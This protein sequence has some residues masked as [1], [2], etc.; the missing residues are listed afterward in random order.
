MSK[1]D[2][3]EILRLHA[4]DYSQNRIT[5]SVGSSHHTVKAVL[6]SAAE[7]NIMWPLD[8]DVSN[9]EL[10]LLLFPDKYKAMSLYK[11][12]DYAYIHRELAKPGVTL[13]LLWEEYCRECHESHRTPYMS[14]QFGDKY[15]KWARITKATM[16]IT[17]KPGDAMEVD[18]AGDTIPVFDPVT[19][20]SDAAYLF[21]TVLP[22]S[23][24]VYAEV[25][26]DMKQENWLLCHIHAYRY[27]GG[28]TRILIPD[29]CK[30]A[31]ISNTRYD[32]ILNKSYREMA[33][34][35]NT[36]I[37]PA[38]VRKPQDKSHAEGSVRF[39]ETWIIASLRNQK[40]FA[41]GEVKEAVFEK[42]KELNERPFKNRAG[43]RY[44]AFVN[45][46]KAYLM[47]LP[48]CDF[49]P[50]AWSV[51]KVANDYLISDGKNRYS[52]P[53]N[54]I[55]ERVD[56]RVTRNL[57]EIFYHG[58]Q[59]ALHKRLQAIQYAPVVKP[60]HMTP[61]HRSYL[62]Y[63]ADNFTEWATKIGTETL[64]IVQHFLA[65]GKVPEQG[66]KACA[67]L[68]KLGERY[69]GQRL[70]A[71]CKH[72]AEHGLTPSIRNLNGILKS[73]QDQPAG[74]AGASK[75]SDP[76]GHGF[77]RGAA[78]FRKDGDEKK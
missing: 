56:I 7:K 55:G 67:S 2:Y 3:R 62:K 35:Y 39:A 66:Y 60:E 1:V 23:C 25:C 38:R 59:V 37:V 47:P 74:K 65:A 26:D 8:N 71:A 58:T 42:L 31:T 69:G 19:G 41:M 15:R 36:A 54:L 44:S 75:R 64:R 76:M 51:A 9:Q 18:W 4:L 78:Y 32:T 13:T 52:V 53:S 30:T 6:D 24:Y 14:T 34:H 22:C 49:E 43:T 73:G 29:N 40:F 68:M 48:A 33:E 17:H 77:T 46:E 5:A 45:E 12:P 21:V 11:E 20:E 16:R 57:V 27:F 10:E 50:A 63:N 72:L 70:E 61:E 28:V